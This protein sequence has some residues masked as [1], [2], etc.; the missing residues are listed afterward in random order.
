MIV[1]TLIEEALN[2]ANIVPKRQTAQGYLMESGLK[3]LQGIVSAY[4]ND[5]YLSFTQSTLD[6]PSKPLIHIYDKDDTMLSDTE[7]VFKT[8]SELNSY[9]PSV[10]EA[11]EDVL[12][13]VMTDQNTVYHIVETLGAYHWEP[14]DVDEFDPRKQ[15]MQ[16][17]CSAY[18]IKVR[19][20]AKLNNLSVNRG[21]IYGMLKLHF[22]PH[23]DFDNYVSNDLY[24]TYVQL[25]EGEWVIRVK[26]LVA[27][28]STKLRLDYNRSFHV[29]M[30]TDVRI[31]DAYLEL[32]IVSLTHKLAIKYPR[33]D[34]AQMQRLAHEVDQLLDNVSTPKA[35]AK[36]VKRD[37][38]DV[39]GITAHDIMTG[40]IFC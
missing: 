32:L 17:Y 22:L 16:K 19:D 20:V 18:H 35:D 37:M 25:S 39:R 12:A 29:D 2:R 15:D 4:S 33:V 1:R 27:N 38:D 5:N 6:L 28:T 10:E 30:D 14:I 13:M 26:P 23:Q 9:V 3:L 7:R 24:W 11:E 21:D 40:R 31:P 8:V 36:L 34:D